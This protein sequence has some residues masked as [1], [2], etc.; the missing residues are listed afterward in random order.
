MTICTPEV[1]QKVLAQY[2]QAM[3]AG[4]DRL[5]YKI[6]QDFEMDGCTPE[7]VTIGMNALCEG[8]DHWEA[9]DEYI[10]GKHGDEE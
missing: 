10:Y 1:A 7:M 4:N 8:K 2:N 6:E 3:I 5:C 9:I